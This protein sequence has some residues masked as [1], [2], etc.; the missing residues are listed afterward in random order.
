MVQRELFFVA[1]N[2][3]YSEIQTIHKQISQ[4]KN[5]QKR[6]RQIKKKIMKANIETHCLFQIERYID[7]PLFKNIF[8]YKFSVEMQILKEQ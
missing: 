7:I 8:C 1:M 4:L 3:T 2:R 6:Y 5:P